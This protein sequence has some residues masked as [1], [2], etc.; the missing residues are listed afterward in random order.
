[1]RRP[2]FGNQEYLFTPTRNDA[3]DHLLCLAV[4]INLRRIDQSHA[5][6]NTLAQ[7]V[8]FDRCGMSSLTQ[9]RRALTKR[10]DNGSVVEFH[11]SPRRICSDARDRCP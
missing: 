9:T 2:H 6:R 11:G 10:R 5:Q 4:S 7:R 3:T 1:M 8:F